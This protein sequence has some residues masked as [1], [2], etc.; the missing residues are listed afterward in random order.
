MLALPLARAL[1]IPLIV[2]FHGADATVTDAFARRSSYPH[3]KY[4][5]ERPALQQ[6]A[7]LFIAVSAYIKDKL[8]AQGFP[9]ER[10]IVHHIGVDTTFFKMNGAPPRE[11]LVLFVG[12]LVDKKGCRHLIHAMA[13][14]QRSNPRVA[15]VIIGDGPLR[16]ELE[17]LAR[18][19]VERCEF[20]GAQPPETVRHWMQR[21]RVFCVPSVTA[22]S[23]DSEGFGM[24]FAEAQASGVPVVSSLTGGVAEAVA[25]ERT[26]LLVK[27]G[28]EEAIA[29]SIGRLL[30]DDALW[31][32]M[33]TAGHDRVR[34]EF[35]LHTQT[36]Q[37]EDIYARVLHEPLPPCR[38][39]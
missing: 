27:E 11:P 35:D 20:L 8:L 29:H 1:G 19:C 28:D 26:G 21:A 37:L 32:Q 33:S 12:R 36:R 6:N 31:R 18:Q 23:G 2:T 14:V 30:S 34:R 22:P 13:R 39:H 17:A 4:V 5:S 25:H 7:R 10:T 3:R 15:L 24:V 16:P 38:D 9:P